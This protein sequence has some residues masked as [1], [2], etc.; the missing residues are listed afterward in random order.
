MIAAIATRVGEA[1]A[2]AAGLQLVLWLVQQ[3]TKNA[4]IV[5]VGWAVSFAPAALLFA[6]CATS[7]ITAWAPLAAIVAAWSLRLG[8]Y[9]IARGAA[10]SPEEGRYVHLRQRWAPH[11]SSRFFVFFQA[12]AALTGILSTAF[13]VPFVAAPWDTGWLRTVGAMV[14]VAGIAGEALAD[15]QLARWKRDPAHRGQVCDAGLWA[16]SRHPN[17]FFEWCVWLGYAVYG[18]AFA[19]W[20]LI[21]LGGQAIIV[22]SILG[23]TGIPPTERQAIRSKGDAYRAYQRRV[24]RFVPLPPKR[25]A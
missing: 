18:L 12:Q 22:A 20:G 16:Y 11:A 3:R 4:G 2:L 21:A 17:Y 9:L 25:D 7:P 1:W 19:P 6:W 24:S 10:R 8:G 5:D 15:A 23:V 14:S 13:V